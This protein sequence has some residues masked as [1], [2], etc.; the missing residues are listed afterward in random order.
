MPI[1][2][3]LWYAP[4]DAPAT[5]AGRREAILA[6]PILQSNPR[7]LAKAQAALE[8]V[9]K[10]CE[11]KTNRIGEPFALHS[12][13]VGWWMMQFLPKP[14]TDAERLNYVAGMQIAI[15]HDVIEDFGITYEQVQQQFGL[16]VADGVE[17]M[18]LLAWIM[19]PT[20]R[21]QYAQH[22]RDMDADPLTRYASAADTREQFG[23][24]DG[25]SLRWK[26]GM[27]LDA[28]KKS[29]RALYRRVKRDA[30]RFDLV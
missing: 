9:E 12:F 18:T 29:D 16:R 21:E 4:L 10:S 20:Y 17:R 13:G 19:D 27:K 11:G 24:P 8:L 30:K 5:M 7:F 22:V 14:A 2:S 26:L 23:R 6:D 25:P 3:G 15:L 28:W 1:I